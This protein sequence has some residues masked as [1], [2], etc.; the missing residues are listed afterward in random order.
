MGTLLQFTGKI[1]HVRSKHHPGEE[2]PGNEGHT[3]Y[4]CDLFICAVCGALEGALLP[5]CPGR[6][7]TPDEHDANYKH[8]CDGTG[9]F[10]AENVMQSLRQ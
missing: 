7:L 1:N 6:R 5:T 9:P 8:Y 10:A 4:V 3:C 2:C